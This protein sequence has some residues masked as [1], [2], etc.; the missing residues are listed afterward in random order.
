MEDRIH[1]LALA[2]VPTLALGMFK[3]NM[4]YRADLDGVLSGS[5]RYPWN[6]KRT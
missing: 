4:A 3:P 6:L 5:I 2:D 1:R